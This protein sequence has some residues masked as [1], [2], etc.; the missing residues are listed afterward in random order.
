[1]LFLTI[2]C[3]LWSILDKESIPQDLAVTVCKFVV[4]LLMLVI[5]T[6]LLLKHKKYLWIALVDFLIIGYF[7]TVN[8][9]FWVYRNKLFPTKQYITDNLKMEFL[10]QIGEYLVTCYFLINMISRSALRIFLGISLAVCSLVFIAVRWDSGAFKIYIVVSIKTIGLFLILTIVNHVNHDKFDDLLWRYAKLSK[11]FHQDEKT[12]FHYLKR[13]ISAKEKQIVLSTRCESNPT[14]PTEE[15]KTRQN[16]LNAVFRPLRKLMQSPIFRPL[17]AI[18]NSAQGLLNELARQYS[19]GLEDNEIPILRKATTRKF[20]RQTSRVAA[21]S[22]RLLQAIQDYFEFSNWEFP[23]PLTLQETIN[24]VLGKIE[25]KVPG[26]KIDF[27]FRSDDSELYYNCESL[28][29]LVMTTLLA[30][31]FQEDNQRELKVQVKNEGAR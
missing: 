29:P 30:V 20:E 21:V 9:N 10:L 15:G 6:H 27:S 31:R 12:W 28:F 22:S 25:E 26:V 5:R 23:K 13:Q 3:D 7:I 4:C 19:H 24:C 11:E 8:I 2:V 18:R 17:V 1:M 14:E 16:F